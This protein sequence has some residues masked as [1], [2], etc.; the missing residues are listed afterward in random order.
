MPTSFAAKAVAYYAVLDHIYSEAD[1]KTDWRKISE[2][3]K[4]REKVRRRTASRL[5]VDISILN[6]VYWPTLI[7]LPENRLLRSNFCA[8]LVALQ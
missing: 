2:I 1:I 8:V 5:Y 6:I 3:Y 7:S 4:T